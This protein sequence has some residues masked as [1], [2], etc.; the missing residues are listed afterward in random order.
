VIPSGV[1]HGCRAL[2]PSKLRDTFTPLR[3]DLL[4]CGEL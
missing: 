1:V 3:L 2:K 4:G